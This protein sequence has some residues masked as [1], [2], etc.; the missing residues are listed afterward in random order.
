MP[1][2]APDKVS[3]RRIARDAGGLDQA[4]WRGAGLGTGREVDD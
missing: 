1:E 3:M 4:R 2:L